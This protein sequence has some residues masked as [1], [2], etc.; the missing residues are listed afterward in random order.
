MTDHSVGCPS[1]FVAMTTDVWNWRNDWQWLFRNSSTCLIG[2]CSI[3][4]DK[5]WQ[6]N[7]LLHRLSLSSPSGQAVFSTAPSVFMMSNP[8][9]PFALDPMTLIGYH[10]FRPYNFLMFCTEEATV[11]LGTHYDQFDSF[12][13]ACSSAA[14]ENVLTRLA[15]RKSTELTP[16]LFMS[17]SSHRCWWFIF[18]KNKDTFNNRCFL[19]SVDY[20]LYKDRGY[21]WNTVL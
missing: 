11:V 5:E 17:I 2:W 7:I 14:E 20:E 13:E 4:A 15:C 3:V 8:G 6:C 10:Y 12:P 1:T 9:E 16:N 19:C 21:V 18:P